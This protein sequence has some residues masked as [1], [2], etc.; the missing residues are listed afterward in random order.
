ML[1][2]FE[3]KPS[4]MKWASTGDLSFYK[5]FVENK[6]IREVIRDEKLKKTKGRKEVNAE[7]FIV[8]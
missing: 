4:L 7:L 6:K 8:E 3:E 2:Y 1:N 5:S